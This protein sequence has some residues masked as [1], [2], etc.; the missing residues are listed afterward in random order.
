MADNTETVK[1]RWDDAAA[2]QTPT[3]Q[4]VESTIVPSEDRPAAA[5]DHTPL[6]EIL[7]GD[8]PKAEEKAPRSDQ[9]DASDRSADAGRGDAPKRLPDTNWLA[10]VKEER[11]KRQAY[12]AKVKELEEK[13]ANLQRDYEVLLD[14]PG[15]ADPVEREVLE[16]QVRISNSEVQFAARFGAQA[17]TELQRAMHQVAN[18]RHPDF[19]LVWHVMNDANCP[20]P[21]AVAAGFAHHL[22]IFDRDGAYLAKQPRTLMSPPRQQR[23]QQEWPSN[24][25]GAR[26]VG[27]R[28]GPE[29]TGPTALEDIFDRGNGKR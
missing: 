29:W 14:T 21:A 2:I 28:R 27:A 22:G 4:W 13:H 12:Q 9:G 7:P 1:R 10:A 24:L 17:L 18:S 6:T 23:Q 8:A 15:I 11:A 26:N 3:G 20:D 5:A 19:P 16:G 25:A